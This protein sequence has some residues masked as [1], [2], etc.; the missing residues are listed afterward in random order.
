M[1]KTWVYVLGICVFLTGAGS[2]LADTV[3]LQDGRTIQGT[4]VEQTAERIKIQS[5]TG[6]LMVFGMEDVAKI[7]RGESSRPFVE[8]RP[9][10]RLSPLYKNPAVAFRMSCVFPGAGQFYNGEGGKGFLQVSLFIGGLALAIAE[11]P[12]Y[13]WVDYV[14]E[15]GSY[16]YSEKVQTGGDESACAAGVVLAAGTWIWSVLDAP[17]GADR[18]NR[19]HGLTL[20]EDLL[21]GRTVAVEP[22]LFGGKKQDASGVQVEYRF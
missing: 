3:T 9:L 7:S 1:R 8:P 19:K 4:V 16:A 15:D 5:S 21:K 10:T 18:Y 14:Y 12:R 13:G 22:V 20:F 17:G 11:A 2:I 6:A